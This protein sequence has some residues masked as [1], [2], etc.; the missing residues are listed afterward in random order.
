MGLE[1]YAFLLF[2]CY[3]KIYDDDSISEMLR[4]VLLKTNMIDSAIETYPESHIPAELLKRRDE[5]LEE[6]ARLKAN[7]DPVIEILEREDVKELMD[8]ARDRE[9]NSRLLEFIEQRY[10]VISW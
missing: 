4:K 2:Y 8:S 3:F 10:S 9:G 7:C 1:K 6:R 5:I